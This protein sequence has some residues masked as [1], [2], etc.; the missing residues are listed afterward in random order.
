MERITFR[1]KAILAPC[2]YPQP[3]PRPSESSPIADNELRAAPKMAFWDSS[4]NRGW[5]VA[6]I[7]DSVMLYLARARRPLQ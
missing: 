3:I 6:S 4:S 7:V 1:P 5:M 2:H